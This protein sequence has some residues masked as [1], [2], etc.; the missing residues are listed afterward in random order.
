MELTVALQSTNQILFQETQ[1]PTV[2]YDDLGVDWVSE[3]KRL[4]A[5]L[6]AGN[7]EAGSA[8]GHG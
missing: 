4:T 8:G 1:R 5:A 6:K 3:T 7:P 2:F